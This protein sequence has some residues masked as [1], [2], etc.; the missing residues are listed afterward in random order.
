MNVEKHTCD[1]GLTKGELVFW[2]G[3]SCRTLARAGI[4]V[5]VL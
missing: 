3:P 2:V 5:T 4:M 1:F